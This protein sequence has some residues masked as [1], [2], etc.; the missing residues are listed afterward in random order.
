MIQA[1]LARRYAKALLQI[2]IEDKT[3]EKLDA[4]LES[5]GAVVRGSADLRALLEDP[6]VLTHVKQSVLKD[7]TSKLGLTATTVNFIQLLAE[8]GR[9]QFFADIHREFTRMADEHAGRARAVVT[10]AS[11]LPKAVET[12]LVEKLS[13]MTGRKVELDARVDETLLGGLV[14]EINGVVYDGSLRTQLRALRERAKA[15]A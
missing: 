4:D 5:Y 3:V 13:R 15:T 9:I 7:V 2:G 12:A 6:T 10:S 8:K 11:A 1:S 14:T